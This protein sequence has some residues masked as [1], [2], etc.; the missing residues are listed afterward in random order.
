MVHIA[1]ADTEIFVRGV[2]P[3]EKNL[4]SKKTKKGEG[5]REWGGGGFSTFLS[6]AWSTSI[7]AIETALQTIF[8]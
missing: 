2:Q 5:E 6:L 1:G 7:F 3:S 8:L 4:T